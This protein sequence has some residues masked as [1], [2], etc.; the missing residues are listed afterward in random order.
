MSKKF[1][2]KYKLWAAVEYVDDRQGI[3]CDV[4]TVAACLGIFQTAAEADTYVGE[5]LD[6]DPPHSVEM[7]E[8]LLLDTPISVRLTEKGKNATEPR[9]VSTVWVLT[10]RHDGGVDSWV[11]RSFSK[12]EQV[13]MKVIGTYKHELDEPHATQ[14]ET[15]LERAR[16]GTSRVAL[17]ALQ[18]F[19]LEVA[20]WDFNIE[21]KGICP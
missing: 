8:E 3:Y 7:S 16:K 9:T 18:T 1:P 13:L 4:T 12:A 6:A 20:D 17:S 10:W 15:L 5:H 21:E 11:C 19:C 2:G 14:L